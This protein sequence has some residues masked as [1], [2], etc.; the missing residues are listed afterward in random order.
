MAD[1]SDK[2]EGNVIEVCADG[3]LIV[4]A[5]AELAGTALEAGTALCRCGQSANKPYC[6]GSHASTG[7][8]DPGTVEPS[9]PDAPIEWGP[10]KVRLAPNGPI[11]CAGP[12][13][14]QSADGETTFTATRAA[15]CRCGQST[16]KPFCDGTHGKVGF[17][18][19]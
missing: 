8:A 13:A 1:T 14:V 10:L 6:D 17:T 2:I 11:L 9:A 4:N 15:L 18:A 7:F 5:D 3:P 12:V 16:N 19:E